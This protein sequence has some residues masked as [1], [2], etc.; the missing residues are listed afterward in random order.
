M[1]SRLSHELRTP[2][3]GIYGMLQTSD[4]STPKSILKERLDIARKNALQ[5][6][7]LIDGISDFN[8]LLEN[9]FTLL[10][11]NISLTEVFTDICHSFQSSFTEKG[12][13]LNVKLDLSADSVLADRSKISQIVGHLLDNALKFTPSG[14]TDVLIKSRQEKGFVI[15]EG[16]IKDS[17][18]GIS[19]HDMTHLFSPFSQSTSMMNL[20]NPGKGLGLARVSKLCSAMDGRCYAESE[21][22]QGSQFN[23]FLKL[24]KGKCVSQYEPIFQPDFSKLR[25]LVV[26]DVETNRLVAEVM[27]NEIGVEPDHAVNGLAAVEACQANQYDVVFMDC[28]MPIMDGFQ[29]AQ[30]IKCEFE[31]NVTVVAMTADTTPDTR[32]KCFE[33]GMSDVVTKPFTIDALANILTLAASNKRMTASI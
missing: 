17:G 30:Q 22:G 19:Q 10:N 14:Y 29:S 5:L 18:I 24:K 13:K 15:V 1:L 20:I 28:H 33:S 4:I 12:L 7:A 26:D 9:D 32:L 8:A 21:Y 23:F 27:L 2:I 6:T 16:H 25:V 31:D 3:N 11:E